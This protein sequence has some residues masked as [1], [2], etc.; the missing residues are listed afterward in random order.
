M[1]EISVDKITRIDH[2]WMGIASMTFPYRKKRGLGIYDRHTN[3]WLKVATFNNEESAEDFM[4]YL[5]KFVHAER[6]EE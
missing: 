6:K 2:D 1:K 4:E 5:A 3:T